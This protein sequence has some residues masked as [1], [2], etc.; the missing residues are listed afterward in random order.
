MPLPP[1]LSNQPLQPNVTNEDLANLCNELA[2]NDAESRF[3]GL[4]LTDDASAGVQAST[5]LGC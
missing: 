3:N 4:C 2:T 1:L 5:L